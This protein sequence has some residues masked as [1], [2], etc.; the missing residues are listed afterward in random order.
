MQTLTI[1]RYDDLTADQWRRVAATARKQVRR[2]TGRSSEIGIG[3]KYRD[4]RPTDCNLAIRVYLPRKSSRVPR[5][6]RIPRSF[7]I[8]LRCRDG[9]YTQLRLQS[10][11]E[12]LVDYV[13]TVGRV[14]LDDRTATC[15][16]LLRWTDRRGAKRWGFATVGHLFDRLSLRAA[17]VRIG[18]VL[19]RCQKFRSPPHRDRNDLCLLAI[20][21]RPDWIENRL[22]DAGVVSSTLASGVD[23]MSVADVH[24]AAINQRRGRAIAFHG[25]EDFVGEEVF[26][27]GFRLGTRRLDDCIRVSCHNENA[28]RPGSSG[29]V[30][31]MENKTAC[32]QVGGRTPHFRE[33]I[34]QPF[35]RY[36]RW[37]HNSLGLQTKVF[38]L[39]GNRTAASP[40]IARNEPLTLN[41]QYNL[42][43]PSS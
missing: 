2:I 32:L 10:D 18:S 21:G 20:R 38:G 28:F 33:G 41:L 29:A 12:S 4:G 14:D 39:L 31:N 35:S 22:G 16:F 23:L 25:R 27:N 40:L 34:G 13:P 43:N 11:V 8:R 26:P 7:H 24:A 17:T 42:P 3:R 6:E 5:S 1:D 9:R 19:F 15:G 30:W 36:L 37:L